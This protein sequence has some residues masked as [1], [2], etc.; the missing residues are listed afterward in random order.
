M[1]EQDAAKPRHVFLVDGSGYIFRA[2]HALPPLTRS[3][4]TPTNAVLG[5]VNMITK[6]LDETDAD[7]LAV[8]F[9]A[10]RKTFRN[11][12][13]KEYKAHRPEPA[14]ELIPQF[15]LIREATRAFNVS[16]IEMDGFEADDLIA[17]YAD[18]AL[19]AGANDVTIVSSDKDLM[20]LVTDKV[21]LWDPMKNKS[22]GPAEVKEKFGVAPDKVI[23]VQALCGD[24][25][26]NVPGVP[27]I[28][29]KTAA[30]L[31]NTYGSLDKLLDCLNEIKQ[32]KRRESLTTNAELARISRTLVTLKHD[33][34]IEH[35]L[36]TFARRAID[37]DMLY[38]FLRANE[39]RTA[40]TRAQNKLGS[41]VSAEAKAPPATG[42]SAPS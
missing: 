42:G 32:P 33:V 3:D 30:E 34:P 27:G 4:G 24:T 11:D 37:P 26:D 31:I 12:V 19:K 16:C 9:D 17:T 22:I 23:D 13:Y 2:F 20:Q 5:F 1:S 15:G 10:G 21:K 28:G 29:I 38:A 36:S 39:F 40:L 6:L 18:H 35:A 14:P 41:Q 25:S 7:H 8:I